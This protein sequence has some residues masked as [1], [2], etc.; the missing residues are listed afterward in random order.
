MDVEE[1][2]HTGAFVHL[3]VKPRDVLHQKLLLDRAT[4]FHEP[5]ESCLDACSQSFD[6]AIRV[7]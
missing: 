6:L 5:G 1:D 2:L 4:H 7:L 3:H